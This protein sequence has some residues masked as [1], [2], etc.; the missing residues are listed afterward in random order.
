MIW[1]SII[2][3]GFVVACAWWWAADA[4]W[5]SW[6]DVWSACGVV[7]WYNF[8]YNEIIFYFLLLMQ[9]IFKYYRH[10]ATN[11]YLT[12]LIFYA[13]MYDIVYA[14]V[15]Y[16]WMKSEWTSKN[17]IHMYDIVYV[18]VCM[19]ILCLLMYH[20][21]LI[22]YSVDCFLAWVLTSISI[23]D[24]SVFWLATACTGFFPP[25]HPFTTRYTS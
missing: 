5:S 15:W 20:G 21:Q 19:G 12:L 9:I 6:N 13:Y 25:I 23:S 24:Y 7:A 8:I 4:G 17:L 11:Y 22:H 16:E 10:T 18:C 1:H 3:Y 2:N 14:Y